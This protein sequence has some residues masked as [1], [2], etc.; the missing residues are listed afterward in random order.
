MGEIDRRTSHL[1]QVRKLRAVVK[2]HG[3]EV[4]WTVV[5]DDVLKRLT[6]GFS[7]VNLYDDFVATS[8]SVKV[9]MDGSLATRLPFTRSPRF[10][11]ACQQPLGGLLWIVPRC[12]Y[13][14]GGGPCE[15]ILPGD[16]VSLEVHY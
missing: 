5:V 16:V 1:G 2:G 9:M 6:T 15:L 13:S 14:C 10:L 12:A 4:F 3:F 8:R 7:V 11:R